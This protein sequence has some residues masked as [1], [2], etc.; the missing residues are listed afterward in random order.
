LESDKGVILDGCPR[1]LDEAKWLL[2]ELAKLGR[3]LTCVIVIQIDYQESVARLLQR[4]RPDDSQVAIEERLAL[5]ERE[6]RPVVALF[7]HQGLVRQVD[8]IGTV[9]EV[10]ARVE[11]ALA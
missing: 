4:A 5:F 11:E 7:E 10:A 3:R 2:I 9:D 8:G 6:T 1:M